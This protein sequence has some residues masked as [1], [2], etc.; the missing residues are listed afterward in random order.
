[1]SS[2]ISNDCSIERNF[3]SAGDKRV[4]EIDYKKSAPEN[5]A[6]RGYKPI[7]PASIPGAGTSIIVSKAVPAKELELVFGCQLQLAHGASTSDAA[8]GGRTKVQIRVVPVGVI[9]SIECL[10]TDIQMMLFVVRHQDRLV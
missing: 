7:R 5:G 9:E 1:M 6:C 4:Q 8:E 3:R 10:K 2:I